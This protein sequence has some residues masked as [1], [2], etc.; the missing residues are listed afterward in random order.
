MDVRA[1][2]S[3]DARAHHHDEPNESDVPC[4]I[5]HIGPGSNGVED[6]SEVLHTWHEQSVG[7]VAENS[8]P[9]ASNIPA[10]RP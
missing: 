10:R 4:G 2:R 5:R 1:R 7:Q 9:N 8:D 3:V 6:V